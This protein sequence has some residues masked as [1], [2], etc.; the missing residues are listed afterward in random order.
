MSPAGEGV[1]DG[2]IVRRRSVDYEA[3]VKSALAEKASLLTLTLAQDIVRDQHLEKSIAYTPL[4]TSRARVRVTYHVEYPI[5]L[6]LAPGNFAVS[7]GPEKL[8]V[9]L[10]RPQL[11]AQPSVRLKSYQVLDSGYLVDE[12]TALLKLQ[13]RL[14]PEAVE[15]ANKLLMR[16][17]VLPRSEAVLRRF[18]EPILKQQAGYDPTPRLEFRYC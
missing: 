3:I 11:I 9:T 12:K 15:N 16:R 17:D 6:N 8:V 5:G 4:P 2:L 7:G 14:Q 10:R 18:L 1:D 13:Q